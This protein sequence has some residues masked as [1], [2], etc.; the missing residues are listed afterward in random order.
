LRSDPDAAD[1]GLKR[2]RIPQIVV[3]TVAGAVGLVGLVIGAIDI[4]RLPDVAF[5][6]AVNFSVWALLASI[7]LAW[8]HG[9]IGKQGVTVL[10]RWILALVALG[11]I[12]TTVLLLKTSP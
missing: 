11:W 4:G 9:E 3:S 2:K 7:V 10:E 1:L 8:F 12:A 5:A 6:L